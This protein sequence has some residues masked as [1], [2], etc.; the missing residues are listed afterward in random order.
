MSNVLYIQEPSHYYCF[1]FVLMARQHGEA[2]VFRLA[3]Q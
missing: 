1:L 2:I 3:D